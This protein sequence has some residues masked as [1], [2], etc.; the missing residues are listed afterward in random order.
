MLFMAEI[1]DR[2]GEYVL[3]EIDPRFYQ[4]RSESES[5]YSNQTFI[6]T[7]EFSRKKGAFIIKNTETDGHKSKLS[8]VPLSVNRDGFYAI[9]THYNENGESVESSPEERIMYI[10]KDEKEAIARTRQ[11]AQEIF[12]SQSRD[13]HEWMRKQSNQEKGLVSFLNK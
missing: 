9:F 11:I 3:E 10:E 12:G 5:D 6:C 2:N 13:Y 7:K 4:I 1:I 8:T